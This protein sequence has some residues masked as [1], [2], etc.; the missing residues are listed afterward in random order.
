MHPHIKPAVFLATNFLFFQSTFALAQEHQAIAIPQLQTDINQIQEQNV[1]D[2]NNNNNPIQVIDPSDQTSY[3]SPNSPTAI[4]TPSSSTLGQ[5]V[6]CTTLTGDNEALYGASSECRTYAAL[7]S[8]TRLT[9][10]AATAGILTASETRSGAGGIRTTMASETMVTGT[11]TGS[12][13]EETGM[14]RPTETGQAE[15]DAERG[16]GS[17]GLWTMIAT[18]GLMVV[19]LVGM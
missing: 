18:G 19:G 5:L 15:S 11:R 9:G 2:T 8:F 7:T 16:V 10:T 13:T 12:A 3:I 1:T 4:P 17:I 6:I 14:A